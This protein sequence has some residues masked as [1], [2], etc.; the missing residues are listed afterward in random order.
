[1]RARKLVQ[2]IINASQGTANATVKVTQRRFNIP[3]DTQILDQLTT[4]VLSLDMELNIVYLNQA[5]ESLFAISQ[6]KAVGLHCSNLLGLPDTLI[7]RFRSALQLGQAYSDRQVTLKPPGRAS[8]LIDCV[9]SP[10]GLDQQSPQGLLIEASTVERHSRIAR[11]ESLL[12]QQE[13]TRHL[14]MGLAHEIKNPLGGLRGAA[15]L[16]ERELPAETLKDYTGIIIREADRLLELINRLLG[17]SNRPDIKRLNIHEVLEHVRKIVRAQADDRVVIS[18]D[19]DPSIPEF[20]SDRNH[21]TQVF[22]NIAVN[23]LN[24]VGNNG[25]IVFK[26]RIVGS[27]TIGIKRYRL[28]VAVEIIDDGHGIPPDML[29]LIF[30]PLVT[31]RPNGTGLGLSIAQQTI[32]QLGG[33]IECSS[34][35]GQTKF[36]VYVPLE[37]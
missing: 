27:L 28:V 30:Y 21:L 11:E 32:N 25:N 36:T 33:L 15:Q 22:L 12:A 9:I 14:L 34:K 4:A 23:A 2:T 6:R 19:Y 10:L 16:L 20:D 8:L 18:T 5:A 13:N 31:G 35:P 7:H 37:G 1:M 29:E 26:T 3:S 17:P 24:A